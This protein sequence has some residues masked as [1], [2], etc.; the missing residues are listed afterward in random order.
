[1]AFKTVDLIVNYG[2]FCYFCAARDENLFCTKG[3]ICGCNGQP[4]KL[5]QVVLSE[6]HVSAKGLSVFRIGQKRP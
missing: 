6:H 2:A 1:M 3:G 5:L 4:L